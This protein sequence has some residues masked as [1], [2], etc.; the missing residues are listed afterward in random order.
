MNRTEEKKFR[1]KY[2]YKCKYKAWSGVVDAD[3]RVDAGSGA[4]EN[5]SIKH[6]VP[7]RMVFCYCNVKDLRAPYFSHA[8]SD[9][10]CKA[11]P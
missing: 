10:A 3:A 7:S 8:W 6:F 11:L 2:K 9:R 5:G 1:H 4:H